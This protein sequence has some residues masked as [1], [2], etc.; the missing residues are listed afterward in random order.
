[1]CHCIMQSTYLELKNIVDLVKLLFI[2]AI[3]EAKSAIQLYASFLEL[4]GCSSALGTSIPCPTASPLH[5]CVI[6]GSEFLKRLLSMLVTRPDGRLGKG[7][8]GGP[9]DGAGAVGRNSHGHAGG[10]RRGAYEGHFKSQ[11][12]WEKL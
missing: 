10:P 1:M 11:W 3:G 4:N 12:P 8:L 2:S 7:T 9:G 6:P 5:E